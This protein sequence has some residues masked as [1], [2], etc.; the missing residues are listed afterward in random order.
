MKMVPFVSTLALIPLRLSRRSPSSH[1]GMASK[2]RASSNHPWAVPRWWVQGKDKTRRCSRMRRLNQPRS[3][4]RLGDSDLDN[5]TCWTTPTGCNLLINL[6][7]I[8]R[9]QCKHHDQ[10]RGC[11]QTEWARLLFHWVHHHLLQ[12]YDFAFV[13]QWKLYLQVRRQGS[14]LLV[15]QNWSVKKQAKMPMFYHTYY[16]RR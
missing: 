2:W 4:R 1:H 16:I 8:C 5:A 3:H 9:H 14:I 12:S 10:S 6:R 15:V 13:Q 7:D 11:Q